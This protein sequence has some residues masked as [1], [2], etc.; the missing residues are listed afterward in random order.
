MTSPADSIW[1]LRKQ[2][3]LATLTDQVTATFI[4]YPPMPTMQKIC[5]LVE[6]PQGDPARL[7]DLLCDAHEQMRAQLATKQVSTYPDDRSTLTWIRAGHDPTKD[8]DH[9]IPF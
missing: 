8:E 1:T 7:F 2:L 5:I 6:C 9:E 3:E 4:D